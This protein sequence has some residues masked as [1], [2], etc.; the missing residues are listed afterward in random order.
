MTQEASPPAVSTPPILSEDIYRQEFRQ[1]VVIPCY[2]SHLEKQGLS[3]AA[4]VEEFI[5]YAKST[6]AYDS[7]QAAEDLAIL[8]VKGKPNDE[9]IIFYKLADYGCRNPEQF[10]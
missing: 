3:Q 10:R 5:A 1:Y 4:T 7:M 8:Q 6:G 2:E 9:R